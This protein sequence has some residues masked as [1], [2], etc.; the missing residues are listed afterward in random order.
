MGTSP[1]FEYLNLES[2]YQLAVQSMSESDMDEREKAQHMCIMEMDLFHAAL[3]AGK[4][5][6]AEKW[7]RSVLSRGEQVKAWEKENP[8]ADLSWWYIT[9][10]S[11]VDEISALEEE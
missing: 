6:E 10:M 1:E 4:P 7:V 3:E 2:M 9:A 5:E 11:M 8:D